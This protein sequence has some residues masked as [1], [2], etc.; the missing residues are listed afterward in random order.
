MLAFFG[1]SSLVYASTQAVV[2]G[3]QIARDANAIVGTKYVWGG[4]SNTKGLDCSALVKNIYKKHGYTIPR[5]ASWQIVNT[6]QCPTYMNLSEAELGDALYFKNRKGNI[7]HT[8]VVTGFDATGEIIITHAKGKNFGVIREKISK[9]YKQEFCGFKRFSKCTSPLKGVYTDEEIAEALILA[10]EQL[11]IKSETLYNI[12]NDLSGIDPLLITIRAKENRGRDLNE[13]MAFNALGISVYGDKN[14]IAIK[15]NTIREAQLI[16]ESLYEY[17][18]NY[19]IGLMQILINDNKSY[20]VNDLVFPQANFKRAE[21]YASQCLKK[22][23]NT[24][25]FG[26]KEVDTGKFRE[27]YLSSS[28]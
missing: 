6:A 22:A 13:F 12:V 5:K 10:S 16:N 28:E 4:N 20:N 2:S 11:K 17:G 19:R 26:N 9:K 8:A 27:C 21:T 7:H 18:Y 24:S 15:P 23:E 3:E 14:Q 25:F 1:A